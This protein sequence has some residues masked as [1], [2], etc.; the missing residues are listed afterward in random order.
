[1][2]GW[3]A[4]LPHGVSSFRRFLLSREVSA[5]DH[6]ATVLCRVV[7]KGDQLLQKSTS[8]QRQ[9]TPFTRRCWA[10]LAGRKLDLL[11][12]RRPY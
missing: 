8:R 6:V 9:K 1:M 10:P 12:L 3:A 2:S 7:G 4:V 5:D 11:Q